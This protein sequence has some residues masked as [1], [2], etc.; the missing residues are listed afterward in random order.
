MVQ[1]THWWPPWTEVVPS[2]AS[3]TSSGCCPARRVWPIT[4]QEP[5]TCGVHVHRGTSSGRDVHSAGFQTVHVVGRCRNM[6]DMAIHSSMQQGHV[7][8][9]TAPRQPV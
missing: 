4:S 7:C 8:E 6:P 9:C 3:G 2:S 1:V 5:C